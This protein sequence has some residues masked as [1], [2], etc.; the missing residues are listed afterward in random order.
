[1]TRNEILIRIMNAKEFTPHKIDYYK[2]MLKEYDLLH[3]N[4][5]KTFKRTK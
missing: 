2:E 1:M 5:P 3:N 4:K